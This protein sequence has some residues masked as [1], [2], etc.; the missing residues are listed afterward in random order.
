MRTIHWGYLPL[1]RRLRDKIPRTC[2]K[3]WR[4]E[5]DKADT[6]GLFDSGLSGLPWSDAAMEGNQ[7]DPLSHDDDVP[8]GYLAPSVEV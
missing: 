3:R 8:T 7:K 2:L 6:G 1:D 5:A 4:L